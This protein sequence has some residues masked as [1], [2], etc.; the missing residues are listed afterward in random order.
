MRPHSGAT[1]I[2]ALLLTLALLPLSLSG[3]APQEAPQGEPQEEPAVDA[4]LLGFSQLGWESAWRVG[5][6]LDIQAA[7][8]RAGVQ[9]MFDNAQQKQENQI[10]AIRSFIAYQVDVIAFAP[11]SSRAGTRFCRRPRTRASPCF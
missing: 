9:L 8:E 1:L 2:C 4:V 11:S 5:N 7:A 6:S 10:K 3:C